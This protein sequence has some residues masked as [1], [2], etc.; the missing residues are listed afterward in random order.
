[1]ALYRAKLAALDDDTIRQPT[2]ADFA[3]IEA[4]FPYVTEE[5]FIGIEAKF[6][7]FTR[8]FP[9]ALLHL[10]EHQAK[11]NKKL[12]DFQRH[13]MLRARNGLKEQVEKLDDVLEYDPK[14][15]T[16]F[17]LAI[18]YAHLLGTLCP[19]PYVTM[20]KGVKARSTTAIGKDMKDIIYKL[21]SEMPGA[22]RGVIV[23]KARAEATKLGVKQ[24]DKN[25][26]AGLLSQISEARKWHGISKPRK[27]HGISKP[28]KRISRS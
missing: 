2:K 17:R 20:A 28:R 13:V 1:M 11:H 23:T 7:L 24:P 16:S 10:V 4:A 19:E 9:D 26:D 18:E 6:P 12:T 27:R 22:E 14:N 25:R 3:Q 8:G 5:K 15:E 21:V